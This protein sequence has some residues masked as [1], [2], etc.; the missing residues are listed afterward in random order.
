MESRNAQTIAL[1]APRI[2]DVIERA[3]R[4]AMV[5]VPGY[6]DLEYDEIAEGIARDLALA[7]AAV[8]EGRTLNDSDRESMSIIGQT[9]AQQ[10]MPVEGM[11]QVYWITV[12]EVF[13]ELGRAVEEGQATGDDVFAVAIEAWRHIGPM[14]QVAVQ[15]YQSEQLELAVVDSQ[16]LSALVH[17]LLHNATEHSADALSKL[18]LDPSADYSAFRARSYDADSRRLL[19]DLKLPG[20]IEGGLAAPHEGDVIGL[21][22]GRPA[23]PP[24]DAS[25]LTLGPPGRL[26]ELPHSYSVASRLLDTAAAHNRTGVFGVDDLAF[27]ALARSDNVLGEALVQRFITPLEPDTEAG[28]EIIRTLRSMIENDLSAERAAKELFVH[29]NTVRNRLRRFEELTGTSLRSV[30]DYAELHLALL[31]VDPS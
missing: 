2:G 12:D 10:G 30:S 15:A 20:A 22:V 3:T 1:V 13:S 7:T 6:S 11:L 14:I 25:V 27:E 28:R 8:V 31:R 23:L 26:H 5:E 29:P 19:L 16:R 18:G 21:T 9:R 4:R 17:S 24:G